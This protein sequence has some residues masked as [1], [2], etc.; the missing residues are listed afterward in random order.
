MEDH[1]HYAGCS[2]PWGDA[3]PAL[4]QLLPY[5]AFLTQEGN[6]IRE[7]Q[8]SEERINALHSLVFSGTLPHAVPA[9]V[10]FLSDPYYFILDGNTAK[11]SVKIQDGYVKRYFSDYTNYEY[12][13]A[14]GYAVHRS[15][16]SFI[17]KERRVPSTAETAFIRVPAS[18]VS[19]TPEKASAY[20]DTVLMHLRL[21]LRM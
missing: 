11:I 13:P 18:S 14:E 2:V 21:L 15:V 3:M 10:S 20:L 1:L 6:G 7:F 12:L 8:V 16:S 5:F 17:P 9:P 4:T 19:E